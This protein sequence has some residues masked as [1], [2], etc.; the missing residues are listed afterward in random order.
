MSAF[1]AEARAH[2]FLTLFRLTL[3]CL[4]TNINSS[5]PERIPPELVRQVK[6]EYLQELRA[7]YWVVL[8]DDE[9]GGPGQGDTLT[10]SQALRKEE[11]LQELEKRAAGRDLP[12]NSNNNSN[13]AAAAAA[14]SSRSCWPPS[15]LWSCGYSQYTI[16][17]T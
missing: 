6:E 8:D 2:A 10:D 11:L 17:L 9:I 3:E 13:R 1:A 16:Q 4:L 5:V 14:A 12:S 15:S 7:G